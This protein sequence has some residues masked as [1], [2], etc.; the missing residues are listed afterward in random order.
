MKQT[1]K[2]TL[3]VMYYSS[4]Q[5]NQLFSGAFVLSISD[6]AQLREA[7]GRITG[8]TRST[9]DAVSQYFPFGSVKK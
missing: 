9:L 7:F 1:L 5:S 4:P 3:H 6:K 2:C 8:N